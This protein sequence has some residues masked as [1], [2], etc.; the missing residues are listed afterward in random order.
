MRGKRG[1]QSSVR[2]SVDFRSALLCAEHGI[3][4]RL[5]CFVGELARSKRLEPNLALIDGA[6][7]RFACTIE[8]FFQPV[9]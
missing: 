8:L 5:R 3:T 7:R 1:A 6:L 2:I 9:H 4:E